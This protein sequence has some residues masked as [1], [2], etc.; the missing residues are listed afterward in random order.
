MN[1]KNEAELQEAISAWLNQQDHQAQREV[2]AARLS[3]SSNLLKL[4]LQ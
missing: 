3:A 1:F 2:K 4:A